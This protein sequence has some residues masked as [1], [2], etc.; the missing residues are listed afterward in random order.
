[1]SYT[2]DPNNPI[3]RVRLTVGDVDTINEYLSDNWY[4]YFLTKNS[5]NEILASIDCA[6]AILAHFT[7]NGHEKIDQVEIW[8]KDQFDNYLKWL[9]DFIEN[10]SLSGI[11]SPVPYAGGISK[12]DIRENN[13]NS[14]NNTIKIK[15]G[16]G[17]HS[18]PQYLKGYWIIEE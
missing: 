3:D 1:M 4:Q 2:N 16:F 5:N 8:G 12:S 7:S 18:D 11:R 17:T 10:P 13:A 15:S 6:K 14:D 9:K